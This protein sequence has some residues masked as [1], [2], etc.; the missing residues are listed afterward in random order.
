M[1]CVST[2]PQP[3]Q[4]ALLVMALPA[5]RVM[6]VFVFWHLR[7]DK[8]ECRLLMMPNEWARPRRV[9]AAVATAYRVAIMCHLY[10]SP[11]V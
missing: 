6:S 10:G 8:S 1:F 5:G 11:T 2:A 9:A 7:I 4:S 3:H